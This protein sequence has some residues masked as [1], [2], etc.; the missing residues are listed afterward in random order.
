MMIPKVPPTV[1]EREKKHEFFRCRR[2]DFLVERTHFDEQS[3]LNL[4][5]LLLL[6][7]SDGAQLI[8]SDKAS[9]FTAAGLFPAP[10]PIESLK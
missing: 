7:L 8:P 6:P 1:D 4:L 3:S 10:F 5:F 9:M 2:F